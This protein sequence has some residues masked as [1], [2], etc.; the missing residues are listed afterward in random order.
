MPGRITEF[1]ASFDLYDSGRKPHVKKQRRSIDVSGGKKRGLL[2]RNQI[3]RARW[4]TSVG[5][6]WNGEE[7]SDLAEIINQSTNNYSI[8]KYIN[9]NY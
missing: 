1:R 6:R 4:K 2:E 9:M 5:E 7:N 3:H 8:Y